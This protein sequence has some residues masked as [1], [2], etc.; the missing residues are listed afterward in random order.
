MSQSR[1]LYVG[2]DVHKD[3]IAVASVAKEHGAAVVY[4]GT[5]GTRPCDIDTLIRHR[6]SQAKPPIL[7]YEAGPCGSGSP[8]IDAK[9]ATTAGLWR[10]PS[11][12]KRPVT[13]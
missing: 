4:L 6:P 9:Q 3:S 10:L 12:R 1:T 2:L 8:A 5:L 7:V 11:C 13:A